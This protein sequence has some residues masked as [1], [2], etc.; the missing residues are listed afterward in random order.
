MTEGGF[1]Q[2]DAIA[3]GQP[4]KILRVHLGF[5]L[6][7]LPNGKQQSISINS[8]RGRELAVLT[9]EQAMPI[10]GLTD[11]DEGRLPFIG[12][13]RKGGP[14]QERQK[15][16][17]AYKVMGKD[18]EHF[19]FTSD[20]SAVAQRFAAL[21]GE[22][23]AEI[24]VQLPFAS[25]DENFDAWKEKWVAGGLQHRCDG[26]TMVRWQDKDGSYNDA[27]KPCDG[28]CK[29]VGRL[30]VFIPELG[31]MALVTVLTSS[32][33]DIV[34][35]HGA[36]LTLEK[37]RGNLTGIP[38]LL[39]RKEVGISA[40]ENGKRV[41]RK[42]HLIHIEPSPA[43]AERLL[44]AQAVAA[45][46]SAQPLQLAPA[47]EPEPEV[48]EIEAEIEASALDDSYVKAITGLAERIG[49]DL[50]PSLKRAGVESVADLTQEQAEKLLG[51]LERK[52]EGKQ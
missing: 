39:R 26:V 14:M 31:R 12:V 2:H 40:N 17:R 21:F 27:P 47:S 35:I 16:G 10:L 13:I 20:D 4:C 30:K 52:A 7:E 1:I 29:E 37:Q 42:K 33:H 38:F 25:T 46:P 48:E 44:A 24:T 15:E 23:P 5:V 45:L 43:W 50:Q 32:K 22:Q 18:L 9:E 3:D 51:W 36:L 28:G 34:N 19:R 49:V 11:R 41:T 8:P 6:F